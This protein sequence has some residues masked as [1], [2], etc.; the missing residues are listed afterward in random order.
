MAIRPLE[1]GWLTVDASFAQTRDN[2]RVTVDPSKVVGGV[3]DPALSSVE[4]NVYGN[5]Y[6]FALVADADKFDQAEPDTAELSSEDA[7]AALAAYHAAFDAFADALTWQDASTFSSLAPGDY[8]LYV[9]DKED[10]PAGS[11]PDDYLIRALTVAD[12]AVSFTARAANRS[13]A[14]IRT[15][16]VNAFGGSGQYEFFIMKRSRSTDLLDADG[17]AAAIAQDDSLSWKT[18]GTGTYIYVKQDYGW[19]QSPCATWKTPKTCTRP[20]SACAVPVPPPRSSPPPG[21][22]PGRAGG[23]HRRNQEED[24]ILTTDDCVV[25]LPAGTLAEGDS[26]TDL[27]ITLPDTLS[28]PLEANVVQYTSPDGETSIL[29][30]CMLSDGRMIYLANKV[31]KYEL[32]HNAKSFTDVDGHWAL[33]FIDFVTARELFNGT[34]EDL[35]SAEMSMTRGMFVTVLGR[36]EGMD[37][38]R[39]TAQSFEDVAS[40]VWYAPYVEWATRNGVISG[41]GNGKFGPNDPITRE[42]MAVILY[43]YAGSIDQNVGTVGDLSG[44]SDQEQVSGWARTQM[45]W[46]AGCGLINGKS[47]GALDPAGRATRSEVAAILERFVGCV[48]TGYTDSDGGRS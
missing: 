30:W 16:T 19:H 26:V 37:P 3:Y 14:G 12:V 29:P 6:Q 27:L 17:I 1:D 44:F 46:A 25:I 15:V 10:T 22:P 9:R 31:G 36:L 20:W 11:V 41:Y 8:V 34:A 47:G 42:Q 35:F 33:E 40:G 38:Q 2:G 32:V 13:E 21:D 5:A 18:S 23:Y 48:L 24:V 7:A 28:E 45:A 4:Q 43:N 39:Y